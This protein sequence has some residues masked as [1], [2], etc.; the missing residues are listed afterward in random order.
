MVSKG[1]L[2]VPVPPT[3]NNTIAIPAVMIVNLFMFKFDTDFLNRKGSINHFPFC[4]LR[5][6]KYHY[7]VVLYISQLSYPSMSATIILAMLTTL[8]G[9]ATLFLTCLQS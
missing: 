2:L 4:I 3:S 8:S 7:M 6:L 1:I 5:L 9:V